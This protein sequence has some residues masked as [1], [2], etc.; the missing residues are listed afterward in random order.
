ML[1][2]R[3]QR[4][5]LVLGL[6][7]TTAAET[8]SLDRSVDNLFTIAG[9]NDKSLP[10]NVLCHITQLVSKA[11]QLHFASEVFGVVAVAAVVF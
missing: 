5:R 11:N 4:R 2:Q 9:S 8:W 1:S 10:G 3:L 7:P 6:G